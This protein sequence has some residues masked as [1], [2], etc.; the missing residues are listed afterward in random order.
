MWY[1]YS[2]VGTFIIS[3]DPGGGYGLW[4]DN[5]HLNTYIGPDA[6]VEAVFRHDTGC[7]PW[8]DLTDVEGPA[9]LGFWIR[10]RGPRGVAD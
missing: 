3:S 6:A 7:L 10:V 1:F 4:L 9:D 8:D 5:D 2:P